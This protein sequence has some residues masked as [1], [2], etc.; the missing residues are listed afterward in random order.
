[1]HIFCFK[2]SFQLYHDNMGYQKK[3]RGSE[4]WDLLRCHEFLGGFARMAD[5]VV[6]IWTKDF[7]VKR[8]WGDHMVFRWNGKGGGGVNQCQRSV[9]LFRLTSL[10]NSRKRRHQKS[11]QEVHSRLWDSVSLLI[12]QPWVHALKYPIDKHIWPCGTTNRGRVNIF[13]ERSPKQSHE[14]FEMSNKVPNNKTPWFGYVD[15]LILRYL[16]FRFRL[17]VSSWSKDIVFKSS[18][19]RMKTYYLVAHLSAENVRLLIFSREEV[20]TFL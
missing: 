20:K 7:E 16:R 17:F 9:G 2:Q 1:M 8:V 3:L 19:F 14:T 12:I 6:K 15:S 13:F 18:L 5:D 4:S 11:F 10:S